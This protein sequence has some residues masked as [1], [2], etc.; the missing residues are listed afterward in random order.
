MSLRL[1]S[2]SFQPW[3]PPTCV[4]SG[5]S[6]RRG[7]IQAVTLSVWQRVADETGLKVMEALQ[8]GPRLW[9]LWVF[10]PGRAP[11]KVK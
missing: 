7:G 6:W 9:E 8:S 10:E 4:A 1:I 3:K 2:A 11:V 5:Q